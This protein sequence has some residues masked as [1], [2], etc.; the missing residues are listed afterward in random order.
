ML[1]PKSGNFFTVTYKAK[2]ESSNLLN[3][4]CMKRGEEICEQ[5]VAQYTTCKEVT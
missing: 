1:D 2:L 5:Y 3:N 4:A